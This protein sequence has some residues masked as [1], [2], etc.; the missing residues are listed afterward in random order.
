MDPVLLKASGNIFFDFIKLRIQPYVAFIL[1]VQCQKHYFLIS[2]E[3]TIPEAC[4][5]GDVSHYTEK[6]LFCFPPASPSVSVQGVS[7][8][9]AQTSLI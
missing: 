7:C 2:Q 8:F 6:R 1:L 5:P 9:T 4:F 3:N